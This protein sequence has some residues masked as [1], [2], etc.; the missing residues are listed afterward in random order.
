M[1]GKP[2]S[3]P[4]PCV[5]LAGRSCGSPTTPRGDEY[6]DL[7]RLANG[8]RLMPER[9]LAR[10]CSKSEASISQNVRGMNL[11]IFVHDTRRI[12]V[13]CSLQPWHSQQ[14]AVDAT[15]ILSLLRRSGDALPGTALARAA[16]GKRRHTCSVLRSVCS[17]RLVAFGVGGQPASRAYPGNLI[18]QGPCSGTAWCKL[19][20]KKME[21]NSWHGRVSCDAR[22]RVN[23]VAEPLRL[24]M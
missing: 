4:D 10:V 18:W 3:L 23:A 19:A 8:F 13:V 11:H 6:V 7:L 21:A 2:T 20:G 24:I 14:L 12:N 5:A 9:A 15:T 22:R 16:R 17:C 1:T